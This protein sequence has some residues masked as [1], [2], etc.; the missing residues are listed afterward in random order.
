MNIEEEI[1]INQYGQELIT[2]Q[3]LL[4]RFELLDLNKKKEYLTNMLNLIIQSKVSDD[5]ITDAII[6]SNLKSSYTPCI[7][8]KK[9]VA[10]HLL[11]K[12]VHLPED[13]LKKVFVLF[14]SLFRIGYKRR[15]EKEKNNL[16][17]WWY[18]DLSKKE[19]IDAVLRKTQ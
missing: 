17:K 11:E 14:L 2:L 4:K 5:D 13:E 10:P 18:W 7:M 9:G 12:I 8:L 16:N 1:L 15:F 3:S 6:N 19:N